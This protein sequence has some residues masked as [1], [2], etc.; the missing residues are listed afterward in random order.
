MSSS[1]RTTS[2]TNLN[3]ITDSRVVGGDGSVNLSANDST[4]ALT[5]T[6]YGAVAGGLDLGSQAITAA[7]QMAANTNAAGGDMFAGALEAVSNANDKLATAYQSGQAGE[8]TQLKYAGFAVVGLAAL[9]F[10]AT[11]LK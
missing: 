7:T 1:K 11:K 9:A 8:Q 2:T 10:A 4:V 3:E 6:D 5:M